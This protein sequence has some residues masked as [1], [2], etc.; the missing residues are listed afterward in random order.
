LIR[1]EGNY[2]IQLLTL[3]QGKEGFY[4]KHSVEGLLRG[5][6]E[7]RAAFYQ[8]MLD[9]GVFSINEVRELEDKNPVKGGD[10][11]LVPLNM[12][13]LENIGKA[14]EPSDIEGEPEDEEES[15]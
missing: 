10:V 9:R 13:T 7:S 11:H 4:F 1:F 12:T 3:R 2:N 8:V 5:D 14:Q 15:I 6:A